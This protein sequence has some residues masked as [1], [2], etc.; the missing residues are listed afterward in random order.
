MNEVSVRRDNF[1]NTFEINYLEMKMEMF[2]IWS[3]CSSTDDAVEQ[4]VI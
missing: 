4:A 3:W 2:Y 1:N